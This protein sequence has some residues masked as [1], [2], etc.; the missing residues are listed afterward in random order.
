MVLTKIIYAVVAFGVLIFI[1]ELG[2]FLMAKAM[3]V[4][5]VTF[6]LGFGP[7]LLKIK[8]GDTDYAIC[9]V[10]LGGYV[11][12]TG[13]DIDEEVTPEEEA[14]SFSAQP[15]WRRMLIVFAGPVFNL[16]LALGISW[17]LFMGEMPYTTTLVKNVKEGYPA[18]EAGI[19]PGDRIVSIDGH[20]V[21]RWWELRERV[22]YGGG[23]PMEFVVERNGER[24]A[25]TITPLAD[26]V[27]SRY[28]D[29][30]KNWLIGISSD[31]EKGVATEHF[32][33]IGA[34]KQ[35]SNWVV[36]QAVYIVKTLVRLIQGKESIRNIG[37]PILIGMEAGNRAEQSTESYFDFIAMISIILAIM[38]LLPIPILDGGHLMFFAIE[39][40]FRKPLSRKIRESAQYVGLSL[41]VCL[42]MWAFY[43]DAGR[44]VYVMKNKPADSP[45]A[46]EAPQK[47]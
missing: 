3:G 17:V 47:P 40:I 35:A 29:E 36:D 22:L 45:P 46:V 44:V 32:G 15:V 10:P 25:F 6:A 21:K 13:E 43:R 18:A 39:G 30:V 12:M 9:A 23:N 28:G 42:M 11:K 8:R 41:L 19:L 14:V 37:S 31:P 5:V 38:N 7:K 34:L 27:T 16:I 24:L 20:P 33:P 2:H 4:R 1:H 26:N